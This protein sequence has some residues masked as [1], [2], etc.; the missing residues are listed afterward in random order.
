VGNFKEGLMKRTIALG[1]ATLGL[2]IAG[3]TGAAAAKDRNHD[4]IP[5]RWEKRFHLSLKVDQADR[6][7]DRDRVDNRNEFQEGTNP[8]DRDSDDD[9]IR[10]GKEDRDRDGL[11]NLNEDRTANL[12]GDR[13]TDNDGDRD[14][15]ENAGVVAS[16]DG[17]TLIINLAGGGQV[18]GQVTAST[19][20]E[21]EDE[22]EIEDEMEDMNEARSSDEGGGDNSGPG[23]E[24]SGP[25]SENS[26]PGDDEGDDDEDADDVCT[27]AELVPGAIV[28]EAE[29][30][31]GIFREVELVR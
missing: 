17:T 9:G 14:D 8:R 18:S 28:H 22:D 31:G 25:G 30:E 7:Q 24:N 11:N 4:S 27:T 29:L 16:F 6:D 21:C 12:P 3:S 1:C 19:E 23:S 13:D 26:G 2:L 5:D 20:I 10:D 15:D